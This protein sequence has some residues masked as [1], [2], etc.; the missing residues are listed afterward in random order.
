MQ[1]CKI[2]RFFGHTTAMSLFPSMMEATSSSSLETK[3]ELLGVKTLPLSH[4]EG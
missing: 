1:F 2:G 3:I 4:R